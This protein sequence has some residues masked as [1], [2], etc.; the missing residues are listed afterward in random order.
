MKREFDD[1]LDKKIL[2]KKYMSEM[3]VQNEKKLKNIENIYYDDRKTSVYMSRLKIRMFISFF[4]LI[5]IVGVCEVSNNVTEVSYLNK[6]GNYL[7]INYLDKFYNNEIIIDILKD[8][9]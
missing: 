5:V 8:L 6:I 2:V 1:G 9:K 7:E 4:L 3:T